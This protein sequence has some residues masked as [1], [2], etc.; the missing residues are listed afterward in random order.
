MAVKVRT[1]EPLQRL[2]DNQ[3]VLEVSGQTVSEVLRNLHSQY[4]RAVERLLDKS[5]SIHRFINIY[6][7]DED[8]RFLQNQK[9]ALRDGDEIRIVPAI[10]GG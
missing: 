1:T 8:I 2:L 3:A 9:T 4:P 7:N 10:A 6:V 5:G